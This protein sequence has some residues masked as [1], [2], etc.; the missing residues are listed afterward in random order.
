MLSHVRV[1]F[2]LAAAAFLVLSIS[3]GSAAAAGPAVIN[4]SPNTGWE[5]AVVFITTD[6]GRACS[7]G[8]LQTNVV[9]TAAHC[10]SANGS[11]AAPTPAQLHV[12]PPGADVGTVARSGARVVGVYVDQ[13]YSRTGPLGADIAYLVTD[14]SVGTPI[15]A[16][17]ATSAEV[18]A[19]SRTV[20]ALV[21]SSYG[22]TTP[23]SGVVSVVPQ[24]LYQATGPPYFNGG[25]GYLVLSGD[26][27]SGTCN[28]DSGGPWMTTIAGQAVIVGVT[29]GGAGACEG[30]ATRTFTNVPVLAGRPDL[31]AAA[32]A[33]AAP[34]AQPPGTSCLQE[35]SSTPRCKPGSDWSWRSCYPGRRT[36]LEWFNGTEWEVVA[37]DRGIRYRC[38]PGSPWSNRYDVTEKPG[39]N[40]YRVLQPIQS[41][42]GTVNIRSFTVTTT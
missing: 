34:L 12:Y 31:L 9:V 29:S 19:M 35:P 36:I 1:S 39:T 6:D 18:V 17:V 21:T 23:V 32:Q 26:P 3:A 38:A 42:V 37:R 2:S 10:V 13:G 25:Q 33:A 22:R 7:G 5:R 15:V 40:A 30:A 20:T 14:A 27:K 41:G 24:S 11:V 16:R 8:L 4:G 28:G